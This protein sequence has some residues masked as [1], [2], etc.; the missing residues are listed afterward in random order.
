MG[1]EQNPPFHFSFN[2]S[3][4]VVL[5]GPNIT[6]DSG[7][8]LGREM[9]ER[10]GMSELIP[11]H[12]TDR[13]GGNSRLPLTCFGSRSTAVWLAMRMSTKQSVLGDSDWKLDQDA[14][15]AVGGWYNCR[16]RYPKGTT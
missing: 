1:E 15:S 14:Q 3:L 12:L 5:Q 16:A 13:R 4:K 9:D 2:S 8:F 10:L 11:Q 6:S 7:L